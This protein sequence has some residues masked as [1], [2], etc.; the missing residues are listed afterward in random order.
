MTGESTGGP[1]A[2]SGG[3]EVVRRAAD[4]V[5]AERDKGVDAPRRE[6]RQQQVAELLHAVLRV[7]AAS[8]RAEARAPAGIFDR[9]RAD[10]ARSE[11]DP[12]ESA[13]Q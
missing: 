13:E 6:P 7:R 5:E 1:A 10:A 12:R 11:T 3:E 2:V 4:D 8:E 9:V